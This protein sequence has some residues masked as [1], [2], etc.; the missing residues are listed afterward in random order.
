MDLFGSDLFANGAQWQSAIKRDAVMQSRSRRNRFQHFSH[1]ARRHVDSLIQ[2]AKR[3]DAAASFDVGAGFHLTRELEQ[4][5]NEVLREKYPV[6]SAVSLFAVDN[7]TKPGV[8]SVRGGRVY[9]H[10]KARFH[11]GGSNLS[12]IGATK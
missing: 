3:A 4:A 12:M 1:H 10:G 7:S 9:R 11:K 8:T 5:L 6:R 2:A